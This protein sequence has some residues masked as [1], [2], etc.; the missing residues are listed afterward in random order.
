[1]T[2]KEL[3]DRLDSILRDIPDS[4]FD[5]FC[6]LEDLCGITRE[7]AAVHPEQKVRETA[8][9]AAVNGARR[10]LAGYPLQ[11]ILGKWDFYGRTFKVG[12]GVLIPR[13]DTEALAEEAIARIMKMPA[14]HRIADLCSGSG[15]IAVTLA[16][17]IPDST[18][19]A[20]ELSAEAFPYLTE[21]VRLN[22]AD[23]KLLKGDVTD[24][25]LLENFRDPES[26]EYVK[27][28]CIV[29]NP[30][31]LT[32]EEMSSLQK[33]VTFEPE[34]AL[35]GGSEGLQYFRVIACLWRELLCGGGLM[36][37]EIGSAQGDA[38]R[39][40]LE[41]CGFEN[42]FTACDSGG[43]LRVMGGYRREE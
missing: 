33:E 29:S 13:A 17:E 7:A 30:P 34:T 1:M 6:I 18:V 26:G 9:N 28:D 41:S 37:F 4:D 21:N 19:Y 15:C 43:N 32:D 12:E 11:Y 2:V 16:A 40:I 22:K 10:R 25:R 3:S 8:V 39:G 27:I 24:G 35:Y 5:K 20:V 14:P 42:I 36:I 23:V 38:V 31:Y